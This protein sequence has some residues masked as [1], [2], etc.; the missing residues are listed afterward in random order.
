[1]STVGRTDYSCHFL[2]EPGGIF[3]RVRGGF[4]IPAK[5]RQKIEII[6]R[7]LPLRHSPG[8]STSRDPRARIL[9]CIISRYL[10]AWD[11]DG[12]IARG[13]S[14]P[15]ELADKGDTLYSWAYAAIPKFSIPLADPAWRASA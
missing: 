9:K 12:T 8:D 6:R 11:R 7:S 4:E 5:T 1:M 2:T 3:R 14:A 15:N 10:R 13:E